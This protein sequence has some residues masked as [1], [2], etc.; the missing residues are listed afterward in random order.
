VIPWGMLQNHHLSRPAGLFFVSHDF[1]AH[2]G[3]GS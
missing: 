3:H 1:L 2:A